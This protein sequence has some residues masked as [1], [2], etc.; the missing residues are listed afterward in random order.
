LR[1][2]ARSMLLYRDATFY[3]NGEAVQAAG[4][5]RTALARLADQRALPAG[6]GM[7]AKSAQLFYTW[8]CHGYIHAGTPGLA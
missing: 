1:L 6:S 2:D 4:A 5:T 7:D 8:Y 3:I